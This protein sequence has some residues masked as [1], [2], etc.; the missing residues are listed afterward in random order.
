M[1]RISEF[2]TRISWIRRARQAAA[3]TLTWVLASGALWAGTFGRVVPIGGQA[4]D[5]A[6]DEARGVLYIANYT[7]NRIEVMNLADLSIPRSINVQPLPNSIALSPDGEFLV[8]THYGN[9]APP[10]NPTNA[11]TVINLNSN[12]R[13]TFALGAAPLAVAFGAD[14]RALLATTAEILLFDP[15]SGVLTVVSSFSALASKTLPQPGPAF[16]TNITESA[17]GVSRDGNR[18]YGSTEAI[19]FIW[20]VQRREL[21][22][23]PTKGAQP[24]FGPR[25]VSVADD[26]SYFAF[27]WAV[28][29]WRGR[30]LVDFPNITGQYNVGSYAIDS[31]AGL[32]YAQVPEQTQSLPAGPILRVMDA[33]NTTLRELLRLPENLAGKSLV[34]SDRQ[35]VYAVSDSGVVVLPVGTLN[36]HRRVVASKEDLVFRGNFCDRRVITQEMSIVDP[37]GGNTD[38]TL[39]ASI[40]GVTLSPASGV[41]PATVRVTIDPNQFQTTKGTVTGQITISSQAAVNAPPSVRVLINNREPDQRGTFVNVSGQLADVLA[42]PGRERFYVLRRDRNEILVFDGATYNQIATLRTNGGPTQMAI[43]R[44]ARY[45]IVGHDRAWNANVYDLETLQPSRP[46][47]FQYAH[48]PLSVA[49]SNNAILALTDN[50][51]VGR[52][53]NTIDRVDI[54]ARTATE[55]PALGPW[56]N[57]FTTFVAL[58]GTPNGSAIF[59]AGADGRVLLYSAN[60]DAFTV[61]RKDFTALQGAYAASST[62]SFVVDNNVLNSSLVPVRQLEKGTGGSSGFTFVDN[63]GLRTTS[64]NASA[65]GVIQRVDVVAGTGQ[66]ATRMVESPMLPAAPQ[67][68]VTRINNPF[69]RTLAPLLSRNVIIS[70]TQSG[71]TVLPWNY[72]AAVAIPRLA[73]V[74]NAADQTRPVAPGGLIFVRGSDLSPINIATREIPLPTALGES[75]LTV[76]GAIIP[77]IFVSSSQINAQL[78]FNMDG[79]AQMVLRTP[80]GVS[81]NLNFFI[82][83]TAPA[84]FRNGTAGPDTGIPVIVRASNNTIVTLSNPVHKGDEL[85]IYATGLGRTTPAIEAGYPG[86]SDD[87][88]VAVVEPEVTLDGAPVTLMFAG[89]APGQIG[90]Y[91]INVKVPYGVQQGLQIP[92]TIRQGAAETTLAVR[93]VE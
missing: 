22:G 32:I 17:V 80:G 75:C 85:T 59:G 52:G 43:T 88:A 70:L 82:Q 12:Q 41:T 23:F 10:G 29:D 27:G 28:W 69:T 66:R 24:P 15:V 18:I 71:F 91:Q 19:G 37:G 20:D 36:Q 16:P 77:L 30:F 26:G 31:Q 5:I 40:A 72:D 45:L 34:S 55:L 58:Q 83:P 47:E 68:T 89:V 44:D 2:R 67:T 46:I 64:P 62:D 3:A 84:V 21:T 74:V 1:K 39:T 76:N 7:A 6:L 63:V 42:D 8:I 38:F 9:F 13:Q 78:P 25:A 93:V 90:V 4:S 35:T 50:R 51:Q 11:L 57:K 54:L 73:S 48:Y 65:P 87:L 60:A 92:L 56:E 61:H 79:N 53:Y 14:G 49:V 33:D 86:P 81:D